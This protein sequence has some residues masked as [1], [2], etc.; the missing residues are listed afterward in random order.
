MEIHKITLSSLSF[1]CFMSVRLIII[2]R[3]YLYI[4]SRSAK[5]SALEYNAHKCF[6]F[7]FSVIQVL[8][9]GVYNNIEA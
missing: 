9:F 5:T 4:A 7:G 2:P 6:S 8:F 1:F 3:M